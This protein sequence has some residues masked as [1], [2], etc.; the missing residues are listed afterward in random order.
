MLIQR[1]RG[2]L[3]NQ[4]FQYAFYLAR[5]ESGTDIL[6]DNN[7]Y[8]NIL[9]NDRD[10]NDKRF[11]VADK[12]FN[13]SLNKDKYFNS[14][15]LAYRLYFSAINRRFKIF[16][17]PSFLNIEIH[18]EKGLDY[19]ED[20]TNVQD[21]I[22]FGYFQSEKYFSDSKLQKTLRKCFTMKEKYRTDTYLDLE[23][24]IVS[25]PCSISIHIRRED[26]LRDY[27]VPVYGNICTD[28]YYRNAIDY[29]KE[30]IP[31]A[32]FYIFSD[33]K[34]FINNLKIDNSTIINQDNRLKDIQEM[35]LMSKCRHNIVANSSFSWWAAWL[36]ENPD[37][38]VLAPDIWINNARQDDIYSDYMIRI[39]H[40]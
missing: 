17:K 37:K 24:R 9:V 33:D 4:M 21:G 2:G 27:N 15:Y 11:F 39:K 8:H 35:M 22:V 28:T 10:Y 5:K 12:Y 18:T 1:T 6:I 29:I 30:R 32:H 36:N 38:I 16:P 7:Y 26:Y 19:D 31:Q 40:N 25:D 14:Y 20:I 23:K 34:K 3:G 13:L